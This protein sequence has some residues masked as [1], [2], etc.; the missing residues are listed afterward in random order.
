MI[1][2]RLLAGVS[3]GRLRS[4]FEHNDGRL[5]H[6]WLHYFDIYERHFDAFRRKRPTVLEIGVFHGGSL[7]MWRD[8]FGRGATIIGVDIDERVRSIEDPGFRVVIGD[9]S[10]PVFLQSLADKYG[11][12]DIV[13]DDGSHVPAHQVAS[14]T[15]LWPHV[16]VGGVYLVEDLHTSYW[17]T[18]GGGLDVAT[19]FIEW[20]K[21]RLDDIN[22]YHSREPHFQPTEW[23]K[24][25]GGLHV[26][27]SIVVL[28]RADVQKPS[29][30]KTGRPTFATSN[31]E[32][33]EIELD[34]QHLAQLA[35]VGSPRARVRRLV[36]HPIVTT[37][38]V[39]T[40]WFRSR[41]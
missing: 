35:L 39:V 36:R 41:R 30:R 19:S 14:L 17:P 38:R 26:Y 11:P 21:S 2:A 1:G 18:Y 29:V 5:M 8:Y 9:Q 27:D 15:A 10:D 24:T 16:K 4:H 37:R 34:G 23:T 28:D 32:T 7:E 20:I 12:F 40:R 25:L 13:I 6:K 33:T 22:A 31:G 3:R